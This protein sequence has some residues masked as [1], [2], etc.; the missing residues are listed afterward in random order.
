MAGIKEANKFDQSFDAYNGQETAMQRLQ[1]MQKLYASLGMTNES[2]GLKEFI[3]QTKIETTDLNGKFEQLKGIVSDGLGAEYVEQLEQAVNR[4]KTPTEEVADKVKDVEK[5]L[6]ACGENDKVKAINDYMKQLNSTT[7]NVDKEMEELRKTIEKAF[8]T[9]AVKKFD[10]A[11]KNVNN[12][13]QKTAKSSSNFGKS[14]RTVL[15]IGTL[16][17]AMRKGISFIKEANTEAVDY[18]ETVNLF[19][20]SMGKVKDQYG[21][22]DQ[23]ASKYYTKALAF[24]EKMQEK[25]G[26]NIKE[27]MNYQ[28]LFNSMSKSFGVGD[29]QAY[30]LSENFT[31][32]GY[33]LASLFNKDIDTTMEKLRS[34]LSGQTKP[35]RDLGIDITENT[36]QT[37]LEILG[38]DKNID[39]MSQAEKTLLRYISVLRQ[40]KS[41]QGDF[42]STMDSSANQLRIFDAQVTAFKRNIGNLWQNM[43]GGILPYINAIMMVINELLKMVAKLFGFEVWEQDSVGISASVGADDLAS[44][45][46]NATKKAKEL[47]AQLMGFDE[48]NN[49]TLD[50][51]SSS[52][53]SGGASGTGI[54]QRLL[55]A[56]KEYDNLMD[57]VKNK[58]TDIRDKILGWL[59]VTDGSYKNLK[60]IGIVIATIAGIIAGI[61][62]LSTIGN[63]IKWFKLLGE[64]FAGTTTAGTG[65]QTAIATI[66]SVLSGI[67][68]PVLTVIAVLTLLAGGLAYVYAT[69]KQVRNSVAEVGK[70]FKENLQSLFEFFSNTVI[71][72]LQNAWNRLLKILSP[73]GEFIK[74]VF[75]SC[76]NDFIIPALKWLAETVLPIVINTFENLWNNVLKPLAEFIGN[77]LGPVIRII[78]DVL[79]ML[80]QNVVVPLAQAVGELLAK[81]F[82]GICEI[83]N[84]V[85]VPVVNGV[86]NVLNWLWQ[87]V[88]SPIINFLWGTFKPVFENVFGA[89]RSI[90]DGLKQTFGGLIDFVTGVFSGN[91]SK[92]WEGV[93]NIFKGVWTAL[94]GIVSNVWDTI[95]HLFTKGG[96]IFSG[97]VEGIANVF[98][99][100]VNT[101][102]RG[103]NK[104]IAIPFNKINRLLND[105]RSV[106]IFDL[107]PF[108]FI[109]YNALPVPSIPQFKKGG[110]PEDGLFFANHSEL[111][112][113]FD[114]G[115][116]AVANNMQIITGIKKGVYEATINATKNIAEMVGQVVNEIRNSNPNDFKI[117]TNQFIDYGQI[118]GAVAT[119]SNISIDSDI[120]QQ[121]YEAVIRGM[122]NTK[123]EVEARAD[124][125]VIFKKVQ[126]K[127]K[128]Y[129]MQTG[130]PAFD[131]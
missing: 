42:A 4:V 53:S 61:K 88:L 112:G 105:I 10:E 34:G 99:A 25:L 80:W 56:M 95:L 82:E 6:T 121:V 70:S 16:V 113:K 108:G 46:G 92:A 127:A 63:I 58:A 11:L 111:V 85:V 19:N 57:K 50:N 68:T 94:S 29:E 45:L 102:I 30:I 26:I 22:L 36:L 86:I 78:S 3:T 72:D 114:N 96:Q 83:F 120:S 98:K 41:A 128:E 90:I 131:F 66:G 38:I 81:A 79:T 24:Q 39:K 71:P 44:D 106:S 51:N 15:G 67:S 20:V 89:I 97:V 8:G 43:L 32:L 75:T 37:D 59:G 54:D 123:I 49:I 117:D 126:V 13:T 103:I 35:L 116:T 55:D 52:G 91:W 65:F 129:T 101:L 124:E 119:Q 115:K 107:K 9:E 62:I 73:L 104:V 12:T 77:V 5:N 28:A 69:N 87:N 64:V 14:F 84:N 74:G 33:D 47:K 2:N 76:W 7:I 1:E 18:A 125:G 27:S 60:R 122:Q 48:I 23:E 110:F 17:T 100:I 21:E 109:P 40:T 118:S 130:E 93:K 31:K